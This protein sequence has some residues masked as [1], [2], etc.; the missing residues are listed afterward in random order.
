[1]ADLMQVLSMCA[2]WCLV[3]L[4]VIRWFTLSRAAFLVWVGAKVCAIHGIE[5]PPTP[6]P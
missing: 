4:E 2:F 6:L 1:M 5:L 3:M